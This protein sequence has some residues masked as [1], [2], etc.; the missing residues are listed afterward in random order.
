M[1]LLQ[2]LKNIISPE[3]KLETVLRKYAELVSVQE[4]K[5]KENGTLPKEMALSP[6]VS[7]TH[8]QRVHI[9]VYTYEL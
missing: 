8:L 3:E 1:L 5:T 6:T 4:K 2:S 9:E 7:P